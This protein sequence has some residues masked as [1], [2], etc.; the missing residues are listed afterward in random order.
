MVNKHMKSYSTSLVIREMKIKM[1]TYHLIP[2]WM[3][4]VKN[5]KCWQGYGGTGALHTIDGN[6][7]GTRC[8]KISKR[9]LKN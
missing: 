9:V 1:M 5:I 8:A 3:N 2:I 6:V 7:N 4:T